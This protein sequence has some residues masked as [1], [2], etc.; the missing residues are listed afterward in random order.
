MW[1]HLEI[2]VPSKSNRKRQ[3]SYDIT[4]IE[5]LKKWDEWPYSLGFHSVVVITFPEHVKASPVWNRAETEGYFGD[6]LVA[7][8]V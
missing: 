3:I 5:N 6:S 7:Q 4:Y 8:M 2:V 1:M